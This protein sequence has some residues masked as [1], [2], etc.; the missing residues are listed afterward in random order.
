MVPRTKSV[1][2]LQQEPPLLFCAGLWDRSPDGIESFAIVTTESCSDLKWLHDRM[3][4]IIQS[5]E[6]CDLWLNPVISFTPCIDAL[7]KPLENGLTW[8]D[9]LMY[10]FFV[11]SSYRHLQWGKKMTGMR[12]IHL[13]TRS[14]M[15]LKNASFRHTRK[16]VPFS[17]F[18]HRRL[19]YQVSL[20]FTR[21]WVNWWNSKE[22]VG[23]R[24]N[25]SQWWGAGTFSRQWGV[26][27][28][29]P[30]LACNSRCSDQ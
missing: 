13:S 19:R 26:R 29:S 11:S 12:W 18:L 21:F 15:I 6:D 22:K 25:R 8:C 24:P 20:L 30:L 10:F 2:K 14:V 1:D 23:R 3:P 27:S 7:M 17:S 9:I 5:E 28:S 16:R 4:V